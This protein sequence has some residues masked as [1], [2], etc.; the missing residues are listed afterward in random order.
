MTTVNTLPSNSN[1]AAEAHQHSMGHQQEAF[2][3]SLPIIDLS[4][5][6]SNDGELCIKCH[7]SGSFK[8]LFKEGFKL[9][10]EDLEL[11]GYRQERPFE[12]VSC[13][14]IRC[15]LLVKARCEGKNATGFAKVDSVCGSDFEILVELDGSTTSFGLFIPSDIPRS[16]IDWFRIPRRHVSQDSQLSSASSAWAQGRIAECV[17]SHQS[18]QSQGDSSFLPTRL[19][20]LQPGGGGPDLRLDSQ[21]S[22]P[23]GSRYIA[24]S[25]CWGDYKPVCMTTAET[26]E[27]N[28]TSIPWGS[29]PRTFQDAAKFALSLGV[30]YL[31]IDSICII[32]GDQ[33]DW[34][35]EAGKMYM[36]YKNSYVT[37]AALF[38]PNP[39]SGL[40]NTSMRQTSTPFAQLLTSM[41]T[42]TLYARRTHYLGS[43]AG[44]NFD[45]LRPNLPL[46]GRAWTFQE[47]II[48]PRVLF[49]S[50][51]EMVYQCLTDVGCECGATIEGDHQYMASLSK[52]DIFLKTRTHPQSAIQN[53]Q[54][55]R[56]H[57]STRPNH[58]RRA[59]WPPSPRQ[60]LSHERRGV[61]PMSANGKGVSA[62]TFHSGDVARTWRHKVVKE[63]SQLGITKQTDRLPALAAI[64]EQFQH[65]RPGETY[66]AGLW[67]GSFLCDLLWFA[68]PCIDR[69]GRSQRGEGGKK[70]QTSAAFPT[71]SW[72]Y[73][74]DRRVAYPSESG[75]KPFVPE[76]TI[77]EA[78]C[79]YAEDNA[80][81]VLESSKLVLHGRLLHCR[82]EWASKGWECYIDKGKCWAKFNNHLWGDGLQYI[83]MDETGDDSDASANIDLHQDVYILHIMSSADPHSKG[84]ASLYWYF[85]VL[86]RHHQQDHVYTRTGSL[87]WRLEQPRKG[88]K[89][90]DP[91][92]ALQPDTFIG[93]VQRH[94]IL[95]TCEIR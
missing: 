73:L 2:L 21:G 80:F 37:F 36:T 88:K 47:R 50:E 40:R 25:Y 12:C 84:P 9:S 16:A 85:L 67:S 22:I 39:T 29:L 26:L 79:E 23:P 83:F 55:A 82:L 15:L 13:E 66:L 6:C 19:V 41:D 11:D 56:K 77:V 18:C 31:W 95:A 86:R 51:D 8:R 60:I 89:V 49:F 52:T 61:N 38:G 63:Y 20:N 81:G 44:D 48:P 92:D 64:A 17:H 57:Q 43:P 28:L 65:V 33:G 45:V 24:L 78:W 32:Q 94:S 69:R 5:L 34:Q 59:R 54:A 90:P 68:G 75:I 76:A 93:Q 7:W 42:H 30:K 4:S 91:G 58:F 1:M 27:R 10:S 71:W 62:P 87:E 3:S 53:L 70:P 72:A 46:L 35:R 14:I 74:P